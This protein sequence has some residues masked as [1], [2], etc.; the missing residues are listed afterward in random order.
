MNEPKKIGRYE[1]QSL[2]GQ[3]AMGS[4]FRAIDPNIGRT[5]AIKMVK[6]D[7]NH[8]NNED[9]TA[10]FLERFQLE[11][12]ISGNLNHPNIVAVYDVDKHD[13]M[14][15]IAMEYVEGVTLSEYMAVEGN[16]GS[17]EMVR[18]L[19]QLAGALDFAHT[20]G[21]VHRDLKPANI[22]VTKDGVPKIMDFGIAKQSGSNLTVT[23]VFLGTPSYSSPEQVKEG[24][25]DHRSDIFS[26]GI[27][28]CEV[29]TGKLPFPG[30]S[31]NA[32]LYK[33]ANEPPE[34]PQEAAKLNIPLSRFREIFSK[35]LNKDPE[36]RY[37]SA[38]SFTEEL[39]NAMELTSS[40]RKRLDATI[41]NLSA[42]VVI[43]DGVS[44]KLNRSEFETRD[45]ELA[46]TVVEP[47]TP[48]KKGK[49]KLVAM[50]LISLLLA[51]GIFGLHTT[52]QLTPLIEKAKQ[53][54]G[55]ASSEE[56][57]PKLPEPEPE[58]IQPEPLTYQLAINSEPQGASVY[59]GE[60]SLGQTPYVHSWEA[61]PGT[62][63]ALS[64]RLEGYKDTAIDLVMAEGMEKTYTQ[65]LAQLPISRTLES[66]PAGAVV[67]LDGKELGKT[68]QTFDMVVGQTYKVRWSH[69]GY[70]TKSLTYTEGKTSADVLSAKLKAKPKPGKLAVETLLEDLTI[71]VDG[72]K[73]KLPL[74]LDPGS[75]KVVMGSEKYFYK[76]NQEV[77]IT[78]SRTTTLKTPLV[79]TIPKIDFI[80][81][82]VNVKIDGQF[83]MRKGKP[84]TTPMADISLT[85]GEHEFEFIKPDGKI[86]HRQTVKVERSE[87]IVVSAS[88]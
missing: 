46:K 12:R 57:V 40:D 54:M 14:P 55:Q 11:A 9:D 87:D 4:V 48:E 17:I 38:S 33:I 72:K 36:K 24:R 10:G 86:V 50:I 18:L 5:V 56:P 85:A 13:G 31:I 15:Y 69:K 22:M 32:I 83:V 45:E 49:G 30:K 16:Q 8:N 82:Y 76:A 42:T 3:G 43:Q 41:S 71:T 52:G 23:G 79:I 88:R 68:P 53:A 67:S 78:S 63:L 66:K 75:Y 84:D 35:T 77:R 39:L 73:E 60:T 37:Q 58:P 2:L 80:G 25:V 62:K 59:D 44:K 20:Q 70:L 27:L 34:F 26:L 47:I 19:C 74:S 21:V 64:L 29:L 65:P 51:G 6:V 7:S 81:G 28:A 61:L 1:V